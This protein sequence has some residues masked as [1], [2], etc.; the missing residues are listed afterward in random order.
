MNPGGVGPVGYSTGIWVG[1]STQETKIWYL[2]PYLFRE[3]IL[4]LVAPQD[5]TKHYPIQDN[6]TGFIPQSFSFTSNNSTPVRSPTPPYLPAPG[7]WML[8]TSATPGRG[9]GGG[10]KGGGGCGIRQ[11]DRRLQLT[12]AELVVSLFGG[13]LQAYF[14]TTRAKTHQANLSL[15]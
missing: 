11:S 2:L 13:R 9:W 12:S 4:K 7:S 6:V 15:Q 1:G 5:W 3:K 10:G 14:T 8:H